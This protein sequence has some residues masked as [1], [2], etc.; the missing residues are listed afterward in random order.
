MAFQ[1]LRACQATHFNTELSM[2]SSKVRLHR[3]LLRYTRPAVQCQK[4]PCQMCTSCLKAISHTGNCD[5]TDENLQTNSTTTFATPLQGVHTAHLASIVTNCTSVL[6]IQSK[7]AA[8]LKL[9]AEGLLMQLRQF[10]CWGFT[11]L[12][13]RFT[14]ER[15]DYPKIHQISFFHITD[16]K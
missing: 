7:M 5:Q 6:V 12:R 2:Y 15:T 10:V 11:N 4:C 14:A 3:G 8:D 9:D 16:S 13:H 1:M